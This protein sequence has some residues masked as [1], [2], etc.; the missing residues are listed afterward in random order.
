VN[1]V[2][3]PIRALGVIAPGAI[4]TEEFAAM[5]REGRSAA[6]PVTRFDVEGLSA[7]TAALL[8][9]F[10]P[11]EFIPVMKLRRMNTLSRLGV[12]ATKL[13][14]G[15]AGLERLDGDS[16]TTGV[17][18]GTTFGPVQT[19][20]DYLREYV[21]KGAALAPPQLFAESVA[22]APGSHIAIEHDLRGFNI[23]FTQ[24]ESSAMA[25]LMFASSQL[26]KGAATRSLVGGVEEMNDIT[27]SVLDRIHA[28]ARPGAGMTEACRPLDR[29]R[30]GMMVGEG[31]AVLLL[32][33][34]FEQ[35]RYGFASG[36]GMSKD[37]TAS[38]SDWGDDA[39]A[40]ARAM[41]H[42]IEDAG[43][44]TADIDAVFASANGSVR[45]DRVEYRGIQ[46][47]F[48]ATTPPVTA[49]KACFGEY[50]AAGALQIAAALIALREQFLP[51]SVGFQQ[52]EPDMTCDVVRE[53]RSAELRH[54]LV[55][56]VSAG[57]GVIS[58]VFSR[59]HRD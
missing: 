30:N 45:G 7:R 51:A 22:N 12:S 27:F 25:A 37:P 19:S 42:A 59:S 44:E 28:L 54:I 17:A 14:L 36:F 33:G 11:K 5:I 23:T 9:G 18:I 50:A 10:S 6:K 53:R 2:R 41:A 57:G 15:D 31:G 58:A 29:R 20:V 47:L 21:E 46:A 48:G 3:I 4:G 39:G 49:V 34:S 13:A 32:G 8:E 1:D 26:V 52:G 24:R 38:T 56:S 55:N 16:A 35:A 43:L 40:I